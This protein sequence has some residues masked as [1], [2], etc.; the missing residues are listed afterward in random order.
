[1]MGGRESVTQGYRNRQKKVPF[2]IGANGTTKEEDET[3]LDEKA[4]AA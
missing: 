3:Y 2:A 1:M 4:L